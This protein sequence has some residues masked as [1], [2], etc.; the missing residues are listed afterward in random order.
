[1]AEMELSHR[2]FDASKEEVWRE[3][4]RLSAII[5]GPPHPGLELRVDRFLTRFETIEEQRDK[6]HQANKW[7][8]DVIMAL[9]AFLSLIFVS[10]GTWVAIESAHWH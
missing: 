7:R 4:R 9:L 1:M 10:I 5:E 6:Q 8:L 3:L 2:E